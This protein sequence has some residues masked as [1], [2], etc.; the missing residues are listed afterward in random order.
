M[1]NVESIP[2]S[3]VQTADRDDVLAPGRTWL[4]VGGL[5]GLAGAVLGLAAEVIIPRASDNEGDFFAVVANGSRYRIAYL[6]AGVA[7]LLAAAGLMALCDAHPGLCASLARRA[8]PVGAALGLAQLWGTAPA[9]RLLAQDW[10]DV[11]TR[12]VVPAFWSAEAIARVDG[13]LGDAWQVVLFGIVP[14]LV[15]VAMW[16]RR[17]GPRVLALLA[18]VGAILT[19]AVA[20][21]DLGGSTTDTT[22]VI[23]AGGICAIVWLG[24]ASVLLAT[25][26][27]A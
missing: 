13:F 7:V 4:R 3:R 15:A 22:A 23:I 6:I 12:D 19:V 16:Q 5:L 9:L 18:W 2:K 11:S 10:T 14:T 26:G 17:S 1:S 21:L 24:A 25:S 8:L 27:R 20:A